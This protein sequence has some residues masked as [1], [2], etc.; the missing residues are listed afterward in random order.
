MSPDAGWEPRGMAARLRPP[1]ALVSQ[2]SNT[3]VGQV[4]RPT[5]LTIRLDN[6]TLR[7]WAEQP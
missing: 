1:E 3:K 4:T 6:M 2:G 7:I 5:H